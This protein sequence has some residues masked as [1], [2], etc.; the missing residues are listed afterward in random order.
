MSE[1]EFKSSSVSEK[2]E[3]FGADLTSLFLKKIHPFQ[4]ESANESKKPFHNY[5]FL[6][7]FSGVDAKLL[8]VGLET[9]LNSA[10]ISSSELESSKIDCFFIKLKSFDDEV[11][12]V[13]TAK[14]Q[15]F[16]I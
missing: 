13:E 8:R 5:V 16:Y 4:C 14:M 6:F 11:C 2:I 9:V 10:S 1:D 15:H 12:V 3:R 7:F